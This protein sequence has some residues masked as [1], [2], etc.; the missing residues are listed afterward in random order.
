AGM[1]NRGSF[2]SSELKNDRDQEVVSKVP[3]SNDDLSSCRASLKCSLQLGTT[4]TQGIAGSVS[5]H[6]PT[7]RAFGNDHVPPLVDC[8]GGEIMADDS[9]SPLRR[10]ILAITKYN[11]G[12]QG[13]E[14][15]ELSQAF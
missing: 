6:E 4:G 15:R 2:N 5:G 1:A 9:E 3:E 14:I 10:E 11:I 13:K 7:V 8:L 12:F